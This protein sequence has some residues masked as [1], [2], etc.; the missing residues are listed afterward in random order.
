MKS[1][2]E[3]SE[4]IGEHEDSAADALRYWVNSTTMTLGANFSINLLLQ[5]MKQMIEQ[6]ATPDQIERVETVFTQELNEA[7]DYVRAKSP[8]TASTI[9]KLQDEVEKSLDSDDSIPFVATT[10]TKKIL[11]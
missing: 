10:N 6:V 7:Y 5:A 9:D 3:R 8:T 4:L 11:H 2:N 1:S